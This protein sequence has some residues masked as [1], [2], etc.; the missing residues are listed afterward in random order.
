MFVDEP[1]LCVEA[2]ISSAV[3]EENRL[4]ALAATL[5]D[6]RARGAYTGLHYRCYTPT[7]DRKVNLFRHSDI[8]L[9]ELFT[10]RFF[11]HRIGERI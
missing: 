6:A 8:H 11:L 5:E 10:A 1:A 2:P 7:L 3:S 4:R 9:F